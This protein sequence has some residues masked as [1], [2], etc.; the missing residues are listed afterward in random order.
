[1]VAN[2][3]RSLCTLAIQESKVC[4]RWVRGDYSSG[5]IIHSVKS[6]IE[7]NKYQ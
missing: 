1:M 4:C 5:Y 7:I 2:N 3:Y 6:N